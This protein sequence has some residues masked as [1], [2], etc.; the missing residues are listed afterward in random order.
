MTVSKGWGKTQA[1]QGTSAPVSTSSPREAAA[2]SLRAMKCHSAV[3][4]LSH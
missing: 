1:A 2:K 3:T 4:S